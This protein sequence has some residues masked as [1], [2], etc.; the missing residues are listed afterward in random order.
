ML[1]FRLCPNL[2]GR[3]NLACEKVPLKINRRKSA[4]VD[5]DSAD[6]KNRPAKRASSS[7]LLLGTMLFVEGMKVQQGQWTPSFRPRL[8]SGQTGK[9]NVFHENNYMH[10]KNQSRNGNSS[11]PGSDTQSLMVSVTSTDIQEPF[12]FG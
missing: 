4:G 11:S 6:G 10:K 9:G 2:S 12:A 8:F 1:L 7:S 3:M 5:G